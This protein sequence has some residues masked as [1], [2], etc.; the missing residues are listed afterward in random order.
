MSNG[1]F[2]GHKWKKNLNLQVVDKQYWTKAII[3][4]PCSY[5]CLEEF[6]TGKLPSESLFCSQTDHLFSIEKELSKL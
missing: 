1:H 4:F 6:N 3:Y 2:Y 5:M